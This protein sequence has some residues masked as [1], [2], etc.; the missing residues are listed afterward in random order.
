[1]THNSARASFVAGHAVLD[2]VLL[3]AVTGRRLP[4]P[5]LLPRSE[6]EL[7]SSSSADEDL[8]KA[9]VLLGSNPHM[10]N[11]N[12]L[13]VEGLHSVAAPALSRVTTT[14]SFLQQLGS[15]RPP[16]STLKRWEIVI[17]DSAT[18]LEA[19]SLTPLVQE[20]NV[21]AYIAQRNPELQKA[22][23]RDL[24]ARHLVVPFSVLYRAYH[25]AAHSAEMRRARSSEQQQQQQQGAVAAAGSDDA[26]GRL[27][28]SR[29]NRLEASLG[30]L[31]ALQVDGGDHARVAGF[32]SRPGTR[33][34]PECAACAGVACAVSIMPFSLEAKLLGVGWPGPAVKADATLND[35]VWHDAATVRTASRLRTLLDCAGLR[36]VT[37]VV[38][39][40]GLESDAMR[41]FAA[42]EGVPTVLLNAKPRGAKAAVRLRE[43]VLARAHATEKL[44]QGPF[45]DRRKQVRQHPRPGRSH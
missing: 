6:A 40:S 36:D 29:L 15:R 1:M 20:H 38:G 33:H 10:R 22:E 8:L 41:R 4:F 19:G 14:T 28:I 44:A 31:Y 11:V 13:N 34:G 45:A 12:R 2:R 42:A 17:C 43:S 37:T 21:N 35:D 18:A 23:L 5:A 7:T 30:G 9:V 39:T 27:A 16:L 26:A 32:S 3:P 25:L 24:P